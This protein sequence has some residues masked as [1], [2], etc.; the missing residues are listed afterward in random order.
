MG[1]SVMVAHKILILGVQ[2]Q[3]LVPQL[4]IHTANIDYIITYPSK[5]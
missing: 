5:I 2:V 1:Y 3:A 4:W